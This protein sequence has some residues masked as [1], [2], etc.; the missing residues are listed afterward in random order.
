MVPFPAT[1]AAP[2]NVYQSVPGCQD[3]MPPPPTPG[4]WPG[5]TSAGKRHGSKM[6][7]ALLPDQSFPSTS[8]YLEIL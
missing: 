3:G 5:S 2:D 7:V 1:G 4:M 8:M 6:A